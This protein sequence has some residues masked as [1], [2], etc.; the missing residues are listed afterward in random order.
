MYKVSYI[1]YSGGV[2]TETTDDLAVA[3][4]IAIRNKY[5]FL[6]VVDYNGR[7]IYRGIKT[8]DDGSHYFF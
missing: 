2:I 8:A 5:S 4:K 1:G 6:H 7:I 3:R